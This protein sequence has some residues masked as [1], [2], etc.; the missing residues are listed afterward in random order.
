MPTLYGVL[1]VD[2]DADEQSIVRAY[3]EQVK[4][5]HPDVTDDPRARTRFKRLT[6]AKEVL[7]D[8]AERA[9]YDRLGHETYVKRHLDGWTDRVD[10]RDDAGAGETISEAAKRAAGESAAESRSTQQVSA[11]DGYATAAEYY[12]PGQRVGVEAHSGFGRTLAALRDVL[13]WLVAHLLL[14]GGAVAVAVV[15]LAGAG[16]GGVPS[17]TSIV[18][19]TAM[20]GT[21]AGLSVLHLASTVYR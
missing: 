6:T 21:T 2:P 14:L 13:P 18:V 10:T 12:R 1:G 3:R 11:S 16:G 4:T 15:L 8:G 9:R 17:V 7:T 5:A 19:A 20:V